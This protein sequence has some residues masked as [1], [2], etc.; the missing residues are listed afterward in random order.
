M[1]K[2]ILDVDTGSDDAVAI[3]TA[4]FTKE[5]DLVA[6]CSVWGNLPID[7]TTDNT[8]RVVSA[9]DINVPVY[10]G[11]ARPLVKDLV[12]DYPPKKIRKLVDENGRPL[13]MHTPNMGLPETDRKA[14][15]LPAAMFYVDYLR[16]ADEKVTVVLV[17]PLT[18][19]ALALRID[20]RIIDK[21]E[22]VIVMGGGH[23]FANAR[24]CAEANIWNDPEAAQIVLESGCK[25]TFVPLDATHQA[26][27]TWDDC[28]RMRKIG[29]PASVFCA[30]QIEQRIRV[31]SLTQPLEVPDSAAVHDPLCIAYII[32]P[33]VL[34]DLR[35][36]HMYVGQG[37]PGEGQTI[38][39]GRY[40]T[41][42]KNCWFAFNGDRDRFADILIRV[43]E[44]SVVQS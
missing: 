5:V 19:F 14:E 30:E 36:V 20:E 4:A 31:H 13:S 43:L 7:V 11:C 28:V 3:V 37:G 6:L 9:F 10:R 38:V 16:K 21:V 39:D 2:V 22:E 34:N 35:H 40:Y 23:H 42:K 25:V 33:S 27:I 15:D 18:N 8:L 26:Y 24:P 29:S 32:D 44:N 12:A 17:G 41:Q 1:R